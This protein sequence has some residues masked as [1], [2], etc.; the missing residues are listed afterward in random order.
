MSS[1]LESGERANRSQPEGGG[2]AVKSAPATSACFNRLAKRDHL[3]TAQ[4]AF[5][6][7]L[8]LSR[9]SHYEAALR[10]TVLFINQRSL[11]A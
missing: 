2:A 8:H 7:H 5:P 3:P 10:R 11:E 1:S 4:I 6:S 9:R